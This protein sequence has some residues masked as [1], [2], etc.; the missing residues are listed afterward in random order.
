M[1]HH[2]WV[3]DP[4]NPG[5]M[6]RARAVRDAAKEAG[7]TVVA[8]GY[9]DEKTWFALVDIPDEVSVEAV[10]EAVGG[11]GKLFRLTAVPQ[12]IEPRSDRRGGGLET[13]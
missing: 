4:D 1:P 8:V 13:S 3:I 9:N 11:R 2:Y 5:P 6:H 7:A 12:D 10:Y